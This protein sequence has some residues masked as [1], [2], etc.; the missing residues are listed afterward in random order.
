[1][2]E[3]QWLVTEMLSGSVVKQCLYKYINSYERALKDTEKDLS[4]SG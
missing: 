4:L 1:M 3:M 2:M